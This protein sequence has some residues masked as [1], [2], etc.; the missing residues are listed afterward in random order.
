MHWRKVWSLGKT[1]QFIPLKMPAWGIT[2]FTLLAAGFHAQNT[3]KTHTRAAW[4]YVC[5]LFSSPGDRCKATFHCS[6]DCSPR[7]YKW[8]HH[9]AETFHLFSR[10]IFLVCG[11][12][13]QFPVCRTEKSLLC[14]KSAL[15]WRICSELEAARCASKFIFYFLL[16]L[17]HTAKLCFHI[18]GR[19]IIFF[20]VYFI[21][22]E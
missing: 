5:Y 4:H 8:S 22:V 9:L 18:T 20:S 2:Q 11:R 7:L 17:T 14:A 19:K 10:G 21:S 3:D 12:W 6:G 16:F 13:K 1:Q 15:K